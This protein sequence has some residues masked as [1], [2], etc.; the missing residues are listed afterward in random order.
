MNSN[1][2]LA[3]QTDEEI[4]QLFE[5]FFTRKVDIGRVVFDTRPLQQIQD[6]YVDPFTRLLERGERHG[7]GVLALGNAT[8]LD[9]KHGTLIGL[10]LGEVRVWTFV[11]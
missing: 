4:V 2:S 7:M 11:Q 6:L 1:R 5:D 9:G 8:S 10:D 3:K